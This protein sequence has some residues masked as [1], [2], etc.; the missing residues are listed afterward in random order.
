[1][2]NVPADV[3]RQRGAGIILAIDVGRETVRQTFD[4]GDEFNG[5]STIFQ[6]FS[7]WAAPLV[8]PNITELQSRL[9]YVRSTWILAALKKARW[10]N[11]VRPPITTFQTLE[12]KSFDEITDV[13]YYFGQQMLEDGMLR[14]KM[15]DME[16]QLLTTSF[17]LYIA[18]RRPQPVLGQYLSDL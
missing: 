14:A 10:C 16:R 18:N 11:Y 15:A 9:A 13:G 7:P 1:M 4:Y 12:F 6:R 8:V 17:G 5:W 2:N 3:M